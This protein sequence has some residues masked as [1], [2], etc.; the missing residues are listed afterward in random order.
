MKKVVLVF[1]LFAVLVSCVEKKGTDNTISVIPQVESLRV[2]EGTF[3]IDK[4]TKIFLD[5]P[6]DEMKRVAGFLN[7]RLNAAAGF[8]LAFTDQPESENVIKF[9]NADFPTE[10]YTLNCCPESLVI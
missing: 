5:T 8:E 1:A 6:S 3:C 4:N 7:E 9:M 2:D 10:K